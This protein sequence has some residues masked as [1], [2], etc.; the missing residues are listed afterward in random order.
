MVPPRLL[1]GLTWAPCRSNIWACASE[2]CLQAMCSGVTASAHDTRHTTHDRTR[3]TTRATD[4]VEDVWVGAGDEG[5]GEVE[6]E[7]GVGSQEGVVE[8]RD[9]GP[10]VHVVRKPRQHPRDRVVGLHP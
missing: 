8:A 10:F 4:L 7:H 3:R 6:A 1:T 5:G 9:G 2:P